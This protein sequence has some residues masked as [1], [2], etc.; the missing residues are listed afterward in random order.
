MRLI[1]SWAKNNEKQDINS[2]SCLCLYGIDLETLEK[3]SPGFITKKNII[4]EQVNKYLL[5]NRDNKDYIFKEE[6]REQFET[7]SK[8][9]L[10]YDSIEEDFLQML[11]IK[12]SQ[13]D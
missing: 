6:Y 8:F 12:L 9:G 4:E 2:N 11:T 5:L 1:W 7:Y 3:L 10:R 13:A